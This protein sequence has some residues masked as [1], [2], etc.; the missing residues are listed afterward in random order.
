M[1]FLVMFY[2]V[3]V[4]VFGMAFCSNPHG[5]VL[6]IKFYDVLVIIHALNYENSIL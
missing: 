2:L 4:V 5:D 3:F 6:K 1:S